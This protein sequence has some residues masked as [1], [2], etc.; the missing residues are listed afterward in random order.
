MNTNLNLDEL[1]LENFKEKTGRRFRMSKDQMKR[2]IA[3]TLTREEAFKEYLTL[4]K[5]KLLQTTTK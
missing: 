4:L 5:N 1:T 2:H 3:N